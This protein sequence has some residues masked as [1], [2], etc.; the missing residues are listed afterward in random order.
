MT[1]QG[2]RLLNELRGIPSKEWEFEPKRKQNICNSRSFGKMITDKVIMQEA[3]S[4][5]TATCALKLRN[6]KS[7]AQSILIFINTNP[8][9]TTEQQYSRCIKIKLPTA[10]NDTNILIKQALKGLDII[11][12]TGYQYKKCG[13]MVLGLIPENQV[14]MSL[15]APPP[16]SQNKAIFTA[17]D[18]I[19]KNFG[20]DT[21]RFAVQGFEKQYKLRA[22]HLSN[23]FTTNIK[24][25]L[26]IKY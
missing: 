22:A 13:V 20:K 17:L 19:N 25:I 14:Q 5:Y 16:S 11:F 7:C 23:K 8:H 15:F 4:N 18:S 12:K 9:K 10:T 6:E 21:V 26:E 3:V 2:Q 24:E 1:V